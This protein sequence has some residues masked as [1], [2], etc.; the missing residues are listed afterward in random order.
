MV[1]EIGGSGYYIKKKK[2]SST[3]KWEDIKKKRNETIDKLLES[4]NYF[5]RKWDKLKLWMMK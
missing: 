5:I 3:I 2:Y 1:E 4:D